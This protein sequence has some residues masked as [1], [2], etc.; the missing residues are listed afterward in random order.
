MNLGL[1]VPLIPFRLNVLI[2]VAR[3]SHVHCARGVHVF[4]GAAFPGREDLFPICPAGAQEFPENPSSFTEAAGMYPGCGVV[5]DA[6][7]VVPL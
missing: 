5:V 6:G 7:A 2:K 4:C 3:E 1:T